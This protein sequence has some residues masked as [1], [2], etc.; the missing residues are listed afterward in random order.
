MYVIHACRY[1][2]IYISPTC[3]L[4]YVCLYTNINVY[5]DIVYT[6]TYRHIYIHMYNMYLC[7]HIHTYMPMYGCLHTCIHICIFMQYIHT[8][9]IIILYWMGKKPTIFLGVGCF[10]QH[11]ILYCIVGVTVE[12]NLNLPYFKFKTICSVLGTAMA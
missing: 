7:T 3:N 5:I 9:H 1:I 2:H 6:Y 8:I 4:R 12:L 11:L 10:D